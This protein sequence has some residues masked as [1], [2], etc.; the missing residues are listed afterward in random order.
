MNNTTHL[1]FPPNRFEEPAWLNEHNLLNKVNYTSLKNFSSYSNRPIVNY[2]PMREIQSWLLDLIYDSNAIERKTLVLQNP[3]QPNQP[4]MIQ[5]LEGPASSI[6]AP[7]QEFL[8]T[9]FDKRGQFQ[10]Q[11]GARNNR[12][13]GVSISNTL[14]TRNL[15]GL[16]TGQ[17]VLLDLFLSIIKDFDLSRAI[18]S[19][20]NEIEGIV[21]VDEIDL[22]LHADLQYNLLPKLL[23][24]FPKFNLY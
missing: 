4:Q 10:W 7:I 18:F 11:V 23:K 21:L 2:A 5:H 14:V 12:Q 8:M 24:L 15:F 17:A 20:L 6:L 1:F 13:I 9:L 16:S 19:N 22:H 3:Q